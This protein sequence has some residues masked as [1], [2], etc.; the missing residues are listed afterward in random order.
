MILGQDQRLKDLDHRSKITKV[1]FNTSKD[2]D[3]FNDLDLLSKRS[4]IFPIYALQVTTPPPLAPSLVA[5]TISTVDDDDLILSQ[6]P[7]LPPSLSPISSSWPAA[8][9]LENISH[10]RRARGASSSTVTPSPRVRLVIGKYDDNERCSSVRRGNLSVNLFRLCSRRHICLK[11]LEERRRY[12]WKIHVRHH[13]ER[14]EQWR[15]LT[16][17]VGNGSR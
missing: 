2:P 4:P 7:S 3:H 6:C 9:L 16:T 17:I 14:S 5:G 10:P 11:L 1:I 15:L 12:L 8:F 13:K